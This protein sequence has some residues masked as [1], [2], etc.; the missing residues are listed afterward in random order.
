MIQGATNAYKESER[1][2]DIIYTSLDIKDIK[3]PE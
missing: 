1:E 3:F 2:V